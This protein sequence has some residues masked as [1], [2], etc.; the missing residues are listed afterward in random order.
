MLT[1]IISRRIQVLI[2]ILIE[3]HELPLAGK[4]PPI[5]LKLVSIYHFDPLHKA[6]KH[7]PFHLNLIHVFNGFN[8]SFLVWKLFDFLDC[9]SH[10]QIFK[11][12]L[13][14]THK[15][16]TSHLLNFLLHKLNVSFCGRVSDWTFLDF[17]STFMKFSVTLFWGNNTFHRA[18]IWTYF[19]VSGTFSQINFGFY[20][21]LLFWHLGHSF[22]P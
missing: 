22:K 20:Y 12:V 8:F 18:D 11:T 21:F 17:L 4:G 16:L 3:V 9:A 2:E 14:S 6:F 19:R 1:V 13:N 5:R 15:G 10:L 7:S